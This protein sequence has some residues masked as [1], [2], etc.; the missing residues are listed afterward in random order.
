MDTLIFATNNPNK[1]KEVNSFLNN[2]LKILSLAE[3]G[4]NIDI[5]EPY[6]TLEENACEKAR[7]I[8]VTTGADCFAEDTGLE[9]ASLNGEPGVKSARYAGE[10]KSSEDNIDKLLSEL[11]DKDDRNAQFKTVISII[12]DDNQHIFE[13]ICKGSIIAERRG[14]SGFGY[15]PIFVPDGSEKTFGEMNLEEKNIFSHRKKAFEKLM[16]FLTHP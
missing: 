9:V 4:I 3:A 8:H 14:T 12:I 5:P 7:V 13:G 2:R 1:V 6:D 11:K 10:N 16:N 15:D